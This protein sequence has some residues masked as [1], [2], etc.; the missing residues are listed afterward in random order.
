MAAAAV[1]RRVVLVLVLAAA[2][3][4][5]APRGAAAR[6]LGGR[7]G[8]GEVDA[9]AAVDLNAT[10]FDAFLKAS[11]EPWA[12]VEFFA[13]WCPACRNYKPHYEKVAK[14]FNGRD[15]AHPGL[16]LMAR[17]DCASKV[18][19]DLCNRFS[20]DH[21]P[22]L[23]WGPP[24]K[25]A[26]AKWDPKQENNEIKLIDDGRTAERLL[27]WINNQMKSSFSLE[28]KKYE[29][30][31]MLPKNASDPE[32]IVQAIYDVEEA[33][34][35]A[36][37]IILERKTI[38]PKN[39]DSLIRFL[40]ILVARHPS[41]RCRRGSA[42][43]LINFDDHW[44]S[45]LS[46]SSQE[47]SKLLESVAEENHWICG[48][49]VPRGYWL[50][51]RGSK[52]ETRG[53]SCGLWVLMHSLTVRIGD[54]ESQST[55]TSI[56]DFIHNFF[57]CEECR[58]HF[59]EM[60]SSVSAPF[61]TARELSLWLWSTHNKV[62]MRLMKEEKD[63]GTGDPLF[64]KVTWPPN[65]LCPSCYR[66]SKVTDG[67]VDWNEDAVYQ[68]LVNY[69]GKK[70]V[71]SYK[72][73][74]MESLQQQE[75]K[76]VSEDSSISNAASVPIGAALGVA[77]ASCTFGALACFWRAQQKNRKQRKNWN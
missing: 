11:L 10:N 76:I 66:S 56:C 5:A 51:C 6:S 35:Q 50:F 49:E 20:V 62:N 31:N 19:I 61:R 4:A 24:T 28:D 14:L 22:F 55:F 68:F 57:I 12:V 41:K 3:L 36:L 59:Y 54:G 42:E 13:H 2:S 1:A 17:V 72:E 71:S 44:S 18:N 45:N 69:Y 37:Q 25:F 43:L 52:S 58:K 32:Q 65:Q 48:K 23:L 26:S 29:N 8:P 38:K 67:A 74:Y 7:E 60:C 9:D 15:A 77:I 40:Q 46:L 34:A 33:T 39:R 27:K 47:G 73:T 53:F 75:K 21:Y 63:M 70:L 64:P 30:E 16:I